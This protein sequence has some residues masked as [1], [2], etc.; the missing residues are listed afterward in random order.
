MLAVDARAPTRPKGALS[1]F[2]TA[3]AEVEGLVDRG[4]L[5][6][7]RSRIKTLDTSW[8]VA[9]AGSTPEALSGWRV[10]DRAIDRSLDRALFALTPHQTNVALCKKALADLLVVVDQVSATHQ[11]DA[12]EGS[13]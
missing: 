11:A 4:D 6:G 10:V 12:D 9:A 13:S 3:V 2:R 5:P 8:D 7:A 1:R